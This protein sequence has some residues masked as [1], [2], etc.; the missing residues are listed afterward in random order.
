MSAAEALSLALLELAARG[1]ATPCQGRR[2]DRWTSDD[3]AER[4]WAASVCVTLD[5]PVLEVCAAV[6]VERK[7]SF[8]VWGGRD[9]TVTVH[10]RKASCAQA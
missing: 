10:K 5:C 9:R 3:A 1:H 6:A 2:R 8:A 7:E 4:A